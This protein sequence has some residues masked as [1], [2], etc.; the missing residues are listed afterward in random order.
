MRPGELPKRKIAE[1]T[2]WPLGVYSIRHASIFLWTSG[3]VPRLGT[4]MG[5]D[6][7]SQY[8]ARGPERLLTIVDQPSERPGKASGKWLFLAEPGLSRPSVL[9]P[10]GQIPFVR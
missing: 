2:V 8:Q 10:R 1:R 4:Y 3:Y 6:T 5:P 7:A 9:D